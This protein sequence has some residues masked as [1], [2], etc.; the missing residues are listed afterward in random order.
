MI[1]MMVVVVV[2]VAVIVFIFTILIAAW[3]L[4]PAIQV[5]NYFS[6]SNVYYPTPP[7]TMSPDNNNIKNPV[8]AVLIHSK[9]KTTLLTSKKK[10]KTPKTPNITPD[11][12]LMLDSLSL[13]LTISL[14]KPPKVP[15]DLTDDNASR[16]DVS[17][18]TKMSE[19]ALSSKE[20]DSTKALPGKVLEFKQQHSGFPV[21]TQCATSAPV[22]CLNYISQLLLL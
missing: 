21:D 4:H 19:V 13:V 5:K 6:V 15:V 12:L 1:M 8:S 14:D 22:F 20:K 7:P 9:S 18:S 3:L 10:L 16:C 17:N 2:V 11:N